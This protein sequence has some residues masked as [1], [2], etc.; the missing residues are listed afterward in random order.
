MKMTHGCYVLCVITECFIIQHNKR[1][2]ITR[3]NGKPALSDVTLCQDKTSMISH[4]RNV[5]VTAGIDL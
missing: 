1:R 4:W 2:V 3:K 5:L